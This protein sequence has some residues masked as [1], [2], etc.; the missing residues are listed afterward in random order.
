MKEP[1]SLME[2]AHLET[3][4]MPSAGQPNT[5][6]IMAQCVMSRN[7]GETAAHFQGSAS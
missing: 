5:Q 4:K 2:F 3:M 7:P 1:Q 6:A